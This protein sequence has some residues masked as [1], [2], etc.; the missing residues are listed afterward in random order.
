M[1]FPEG[2]LWGTASAGYPTEGHLETTDWHRYIEADL[3]RPP[4]RRR[5][6]EPVGLACDHWNRYEEDHRLAGL[7]GIQ[8][9]RMSV[10]WARIV[11]ERGRID[12]KALERYG[13]MLDS[14]RRHRVKVMLTL[15]HFTI[16]AWLEDLGGFLNR[17]P[18]MQHYR[19]YVR[20]VVESF[21]PRVDYWLPVNDPNVVPVAGFLFGRIPP[22][23]KDPLGFIRAYHTLID[24]HASAYR[25]I[26][27]HGSS[28]PVGAGLVWAQ[29]RP[30]R[31]RNPLDR[32]GAWL[33]DRGVN[34]VF[35]DAIE[36]GRLTFPIGAGRRIPHAKGALDFIGHNYHRTRF[37]RALAVQD[38]P[39]DAVA[40]GGGGPAWPEGMYLS[41]KRVASRLDLPIIV[42][43]NGVGTE[44]EAFRI[45]FIRNHLV[46]VHRAIREGVPVRGYLHWSLTDKWEW[47]R[48]FEPRFGL[49]QVD[50]PSRERTIKQS[51][52]WYA[53]L[54]RENALE[55]A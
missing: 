21:A 30:D 27:E 8:V 25:I 40:S 26:K 5:F 16:P 28:A 29:M 19:D 51:G 49:I 34:Q 33:G 36:T 46:Q 43:G 48:G 4:G 14:L 44:D 13:R 39:P 45:R 11:P 54:I 24:M 6:A 15:H 17:D 53:Q 10:E 20:C 41:L 12:E 37:C 32:F 35:Y 31:E 55:P 42:T 22:F 52:W 23:R 50:Y 9:H 18:F 7:L 3:E 2:F 38:R 47:T 1:K